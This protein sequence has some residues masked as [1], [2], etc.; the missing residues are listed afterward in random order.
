M[1]RYCPAS[2]QTSGSGKHPKREDFHIYAPAVLPA[3]PGIQKTASNHQ[4]IT[5]K[6]NPNFKINAV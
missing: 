1:P 6:N 5:G 3:L 4:N 2:F